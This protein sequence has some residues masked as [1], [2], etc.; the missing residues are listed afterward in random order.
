M[1]L[2][3]NNSSWVGPEEQFVDKHVLGRT[4]TRITGLKIDSDTVKIFFGDEARLEMYHDQYCCE[5]VRIVDIIGD[6][7]DIIGSPLTMFEEVTQSNEELAREYTEYLNDE[8]TWTF[9]KLATIKGYI[10]I[11][12]LG[13]S[14][15]YYS[16]K[17]TLDYYQQGMSSK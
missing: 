8:H 5:M 7:E 17:V 1:E 11:R 3:A 13:E 2:F 9:Y 15:G 16:E 10:T 14:N 6:V 4:I 12:W